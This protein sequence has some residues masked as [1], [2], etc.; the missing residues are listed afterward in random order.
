MEVFVTVV[1]QGSF[2]AAAR[3]LGV[4]T[5][6]V[7]RQVSRIEDRLKVRL[8][9]RST[10]S[11]TPTD[12]GWTYY[13]RAKQIVLDIQEAEAAVTKLQ[14]V[15][16]GH[17][18]LSAPPTSAREDLI[19]TLLPAFMRAYPE[20]TCELVV[21]SRYVDLV[22]EGF[23]LALRGGTLKD[24]SL[25]VRTLVT[26][27]IGAV[28]SPAYLDERGRPDTTEQLEGHE[29]ILYRGQEGPSR[30][31]LTTG[32]WLTM[33]GH[34]ITNDMAVVSKAAVAGLGIAVLPLGFVRHEL[35]TGMLEQVL[36]GVIGR[37]TN[38]QL[39]YPSGR[40]LPAKVRAFIDFAVEFV[41]A[42]PV[43]SVTG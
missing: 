2:A 13:D 11:L 24:S 37:R 42:N 10:R 9:H 18:R 1:D 21:A 16:R 31:P 35:E 15:P 5:S 32:E 29:F 4:P 27:C 33:E 43:P 25:V 17:L 7:S 40:H 26:S 8:L 22:E 41:K 28:A 38:L 12:A 14:T 3:Q 34:L 6:T 30:W 36:V 20:V 39:V 23:D 19:E